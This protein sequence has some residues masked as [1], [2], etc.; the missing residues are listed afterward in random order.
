MKA[1]IFI[2]SLLIVSV[3]YGA[4]TCQDLQNEDLESK[5]VGEG[6]VLTKENW[7]NIDVIVGFNRQE[8]LDIVAQQ[9]IEVNGERFWQFN[10]TDDSC[11]GGNTYG[12]IYSEDLKIPIAH[13]YDGDIVCQ[14]DGWREED[15]AS[16]HKCD[17]AAESLAQQKMKEFG[18]EFENLSSAIELRDPYIYS[19][20]YV[21]GTITNK[22][23]K[24]AIVKVLTDIETC[25]F[26]SVSIDNLEL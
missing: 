8:C 25:K 5:L 24:S 3:S 20:V 10:T 2:F 18:F 17:L 7:K 4:V 16:N 15:R 26:A 23:N 19:Y 22:E 14:E 12:S 1:F 11:D 21:S 9:L 6:N 13:I